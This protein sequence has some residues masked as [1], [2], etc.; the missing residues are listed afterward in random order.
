VVCSVE[1]AQEGTGESIM[2]W[3]LNLSKTQKMAERVLG[4]L[5]D[6]LEHRPKNRYATQANAVDLQDAL[7]IR[8]CTPPSSK[9]KDSGKSRIK[10]NVN[11]RRTNAGR[12]KWFDAK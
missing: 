6:K 7:Q 11:F 12:D 10:E 5:Q 8:N 9:L 3:N 2:D 1:R 4:G